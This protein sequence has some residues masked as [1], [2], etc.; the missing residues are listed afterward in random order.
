LPIYAVTMFLSAFLL[1][2]VQPM[3]A[4]RILPWF[5]GTP[6]VW[7]T[8]MLFFQVA[9]LGGYA[10]AHWIS[11]RLTPR[12]QVIAHLA[13]IAVA[14]S[15]LPVYPGPEF[16][17]ADPDHPAARILLLLGFTVLMPYFVLSA[18]SPLVQRWFSLRRP[19]RSPYVLYALSNAGSLLAL[20][21]YVA[22][23]EP[24][25]SSKAHAVVWAVGFAMYA[26]LCGLCARQIWQIPSA[27]AR[28]AG[29]AEEPDRSPH[30]LSRAL[31]LLLP[32][33]GSML[34]LAVTN[35]LCQ[36]VAVVPFL[37]VLPLGLYLLSF[38]FCFE[39]DRWY[40]RGVFWPLA[41]IVTVAILGLMFKKITAGFVAE[42]AIYSLALFAL[43]M[44]CHGELAR[45][46]PAPKRLTSFYLRVSAGGALGAVF[47]ALIAP[48]IFKT[49]VELN[50]A[51]WGCCALGVLAAWHER[52]LR[53][54]EEVRRRAALRFAPAMLVLTAFGVGFGAQIPWSI[55]GKPILMRNFYG[56]LR[57]RTVRLKDPDREI[58]SLV[59][60]ATYHGWQILS[61]PDRPT[62][63]YG[64]ESGVGL[65]LQYCPRS[66]DPSAVSSGPNGLSV[67]VAGLGVGTVA[68]YGRKEDT[69]RFYE[70]NPAVAE[71]A[72]TDFSFLKR[73]RARWDIVL[74]DA[75]L[76]LER[77]E[78]R[79]FDLLVLDA[80][81]GDAIPV[82][83]LTREA[84]Q[85]YLRRLRPHGV[86][87]INIS[88]NW[89]DLE[90]VVRGVAESFHLGWRVIA[91]AGDPERGTE[92][93]LWMLLS[94]DFNFLDRPE[95]RLASG[96]LRRSR[97]GILWT[98]DHNNL[99]RILNWRQDLVPT[100]ASREKTEAAT[101]GR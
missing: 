28:D 74:G 77:D 93:A 90:P 8:C 1:F 99:F 97:P 29:G 52:R 32:F 87:A 20:P 66:P 10:Y 56:I 44:V 78:G 14:L 31:W 27:P 83:L 15:F 68:A 81:N 76:S 2:L 7:T 6:A 75:R 23:F 37:W 84:F 62:A 38:I 94:A 60:G 35:Q 43:C 59:H 21:V 16:Q 3:I 42:A 34:L 86:I 45:L 46:K 36:E 19:G 30:P 11:T 47:V 88:N 61:D 24:T 50:L 72:T 55:H 13:L 33:G 53:R 82:H 80:F 63:Y 49:F 57:V 91:S 89:L 64:P 79:Q 25:M 69:F 48:M 40:R 98:D 101:T 67:G 54:P 51:L 71:L 12:R 18:T 73:S 85:V 17:P 5:G 58:R 70:I 26:I 39:S 22:L 92:R 4:K 9:L 95:I 100:L 41:A 96:R 65:A